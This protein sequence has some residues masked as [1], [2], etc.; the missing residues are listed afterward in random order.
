[1]NELDRVLFLDKGAH[2]TFYV[3]RVPPRACYEIPI[4][5]CNKSSVIFLIFWRRRRIFLRFREGLQ[6]VFRARG[7]RKPRWH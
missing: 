5:Q 1:M 7:V 3:R 6:G 4:R 2:T